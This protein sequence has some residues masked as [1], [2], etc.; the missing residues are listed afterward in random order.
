MRENGIHKVHFIGIAGSGMQGL[1]EVAHA[2]GYEVTGS[3]PNYAAITHS[4]I[5]E[6]SGVHDASWI[7]KELDVVVVS[8]AI[9][10]NHQEILAAG[11]LGIT[12]WH[13]SDFLKYL[14]KD[15]KLIAVAGTH[16][17]TTTT[18]LLAYS[19]DALGYQPTAVIGGKRGDCG[20]SSYTGEGEYFIAEVDESDG[21]FLK[22]APFISVITNID[23]DHL[24][25]Y[26]DLADIQDAF[27]KFAGSTDQDG[28]IVINWDDTNSQN[29]A[30]E[31]EELDR[32][33]FGKKLGSDLRLL[34]HTPKGV[35][36]EFSAMVL[37]TK[38]TAT[39][40]LLGL[41]NLFNVLSVLGVLQSLEADIAQG[42]KALEKFP[43]V[44]KRSQCL[45]SSE[46][47][48]LY[49]DYAHNPGKISA[50]LK[51][52]AA[53]FPKAEICAIFEPHRF[54]RVKTMYNEFSQAF[55]AADLVIV[56]PVFAAGETHDPSYDS[57]GFALDIARASEVR[58]LPVAREVAS[59][60]LDH[61]SEEREQVFICLGAGC[62]SE[63]AYQLRDSLSGKNQIKKE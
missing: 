22:F 6:N 29:L 58:C 60:V 11:K 32:L 15:Q 56:C 7:K 4:T 24:D 49:D 27:L 37:R 35:M 34:S 63:Y 52:I 9:Q 8:T 25:H 51:A 2:R 40:P 42:L 3:D 20:H 46:K 13:R 62:A 45:F 44:R 31:L 10:K 17:K 18:A 33:A 30:H 5:R 28:T 57:S 41:H 54:S 14:A 1:A 59:F 48:Y 26:K 55:Q 50:C 12:L 38:H 36:T 19:L 16:G 61:V 53:A 47:T 21:S 43:G 23:L 39:L